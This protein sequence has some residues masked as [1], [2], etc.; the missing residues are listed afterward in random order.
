MG[1]DLQEFSNITRSNCFLAMA[2]FL[3][4]QIG[5]KTNLI[6]S[7]HFWK[8]NRLC[9]TFSFILSIRR[10]KVVLKRLLPNIYISSLD[11]SCGNKNLPPDKMSGKSKVLP[12]TKPI[13][14]FS[15]RTN[16]RCPA[17]F[18][19]L[20]TSLRRAKIIFTPKNIISITTIIILEGIQKGN[21]EL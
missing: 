19:G 2:L 6:I 8:L 16:V 12:R 4:H 3:G 9:T 5:F 21:Q 17:L 14:D 13:F 1:T 15:S 18:Q 7:S 20:K 10:T 11:I